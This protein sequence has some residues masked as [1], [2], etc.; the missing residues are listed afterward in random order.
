MRRLAVVALL[1]LAGC[2]APEKGVVE[3]K[4]YHQPYTW[5]DMVCSS[6]TEKGT[7]RMSIPVVR[8]EPA[9][10]E[11]CLRDGEETGCRIVDETTFHKYE[12]GQ[13]Y[14]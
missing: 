13:M 3:D 4:R 11:L 5:V 6:Y 12:R 1:L 8:S 14:P 9:R 10:W 7:C 2:S